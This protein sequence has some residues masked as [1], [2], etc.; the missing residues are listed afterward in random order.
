MGVG[1]Q[2]DTP[3][4]LHP[5]M[6]RNLLYRWLGGLQGLSRRVRKISPPTGVRFTARPAGSKS[7]YRLRYPS[8]PVLSLYLGIRMPLRSLFGPTESIRNAKAV[9]I[10]FGFLKQ[11]FAK[12]G[13][14]FHLTRLKLMAF[15]TKEHMHAGVSTPE[16]NDFFWPSSRPMDVK[17]NDNNYKKSW[18]L[19][20]LFRPDYRQ[21]L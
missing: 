21:K 10:H 18:I 7:L 16:S 9:L 1:G 4:A 6:T 17:F 15:S 5:G 19:H 11:E 3:A 20:L 2:R 13:P 12:N 14:K 8:P